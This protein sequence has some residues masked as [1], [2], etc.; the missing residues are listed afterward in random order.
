[1]P[2]A[3]HTLGAVQIPRGMIWVDEMDWCPV[4]SSAEYGLT[5]SLIV[6]ASVKT[7][8]RP[9][10]LQGADDQ[11]HIRRSVLQSLKALAETPLATYT[12]TLADGQVFTVRFAPDET[13]VEARPIG[14]PEAPG[15]SYRYV[16][17]VRLVT[18]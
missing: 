15:D 6:D 11:G 3:H 4:D 17:T 18:V 12:L 10:T 8:G 14:R 9:I 13:P 1:M 5:G 16:A 2:A 7:N